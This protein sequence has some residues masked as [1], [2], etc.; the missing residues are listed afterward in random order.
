MLT[1]VSWAPFTK[2]LLFNEGII[3]RVNVKHK[4][5]CRRSSDPV[6]SKSL[7]P[8][9]QDFLLGNVDKKMYSKVRYWEDLSLSPSCLFRATPEWAQ[10]SRWSTS[11]CCQP[12]T[13]HLVTG[14][15]WIS[16]ISWNKLRERW[17]HGTYSPARKVDN[18]LFQFF[19]WGSFKAGL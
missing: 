4:Y 6:S 11:A 9:D 18:I 8:T 2:N 3:L 15:L 1:Q 16:V 14:K 5:S 13:H 12:Q 17:Q 10:I 7:T 19:P